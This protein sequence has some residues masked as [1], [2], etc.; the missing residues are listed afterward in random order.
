M[1]WRLT[2]VQSECKTKFTYRVICILNKNRYS[3]YII[4]NLVACRAIFRYCVYQ[5][6]NSQCK[7]TH[8]K[9]KLN[10]VLSNHWITMLG[11]PRGHQV[12]LSIPQMLLPTSV[13]L[14][15]ITWIIETNIWLLALMFVLNIQ[16]F[17]IYIWLLVK[18]KSLFQVTNMISEGRNHI[19]TAN[20]NLLYFTL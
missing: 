11:I 20:T 19:P 5:S 9:V 3:T 1:N 4:S 16:I 14:G 2:V 7:Q 15:R 8:I 18:P 10:G 13:N 12:C 6:N 17:N